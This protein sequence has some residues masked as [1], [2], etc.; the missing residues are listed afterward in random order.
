MAPT[1]TIVLPTQRRPE[2]LQVALAS[3]VPQARAA[4]VPVLVIDDG[5]SPETRAVA[6][7]HGA[8]YVAHDAPRGLNAARNTA[9]DST[10]SDLLIFVDDDVAVHAGWLAALLDA[11]AHLPDEVGVLT[12]PIV[13]VFEDHR[14]GMC[15]REGAPITFLDHG[16]DDVDAP[17]AWGANMTVRRSAIHRAGRFDASRP[18][19]GDEAEWQDAFKAAG[20]RIRYIAA[21]GLDHRRAGDDSRLRSLS[22]SA[23]SR[24]RASRRH[25]V[26]KARAPSLRRELRVLAGCAVHTL[27]FRCANGI[28]MAAHSIGRVR[29]AWDPT[30][31]AATPGVDDFLSG[32]SGTVGGLRGRGR[33]LRDLAADLQTLPARAAARRHAAAGHAHARVLVLGVER[34]GSLMPAALDELRRSGHELTTAVGPGAPGLGKFANLNAQLADHELE[35]ADW[36]LV[37]DDDVALPRGF[38]DVLVDQASQAGLKL[39]QPAHRHHSHAAWPVT[40]RHGAGVRRTTFVEIGPV[41]LFHRDTFASLLPFPEQLQMGWGLD[42][43]WAALAARNGWPIGVVDAVPV[44]HTVAPVGTGYSRDAALAEARAF[45]AHRPYV[46][47]DEV[48][49]VEGAR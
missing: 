38:L 9:I 26:F 31:P 29:E 33:R 23:Y 24:G 3:I 17:Y 15:G 32:V 22:R 14:L 19:Y 20:G 7:R 25:D 11:A 39:A 48:R 13:P 34:P 49:T 10:G 36:L 44:G 40:R 2:Y 43:H 5:P 21:A 30:P 12:G 45:L 1:A 37:L 27:R 8:R 42:A 46:R 18:L 4:G 41:T 47:R 28:V 35:H 16:P 6:V